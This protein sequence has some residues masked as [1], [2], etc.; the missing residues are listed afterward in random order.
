MFDPKSNGYNLVFD[1][2]NF[3]GF[4]PSQKKSKSTGVIIPVRGNQG[5]Y[6]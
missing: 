1:K 2:K 4:N 5:E 3:G 6:I